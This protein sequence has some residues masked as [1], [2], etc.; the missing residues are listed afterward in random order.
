MN[1]HASR[2]IVLVV[3]KM[4]VVSGLVGSLYTVI[5]RYSEK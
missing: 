4:K 3:C 1:T 2:I 5:L